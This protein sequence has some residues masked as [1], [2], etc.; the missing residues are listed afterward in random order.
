[1][2][3]NLQAVV[4]YGFGK[5]AAVPGVNVGGKSGTAE[6]VPGAAPHAWYIS[7]APLEA[8]RFAVAVMIENGG[9]GSSVGAQLAGEVMAAALRLEGGQ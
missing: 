6:N 5:A 8:P 3:H 4:Q 9:E 2:R 1:M 7:I